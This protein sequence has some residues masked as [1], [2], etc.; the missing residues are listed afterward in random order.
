MKLELERKDPSK[1][2]ASKPESFTVKQALMTTNV[3]TLT[4]LKAKEIID[5]PSKEGDPYGLDKPEETIVLAG[6]KLEQTLVLGKAVEKKGAFS[7]EPD[8]YCRI[9]GEATV[10]LIDG[11]S[12]KGLKTDPAE[13]RDR[14]VLSFNPADIERLRDRA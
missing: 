5:E 1:W 3:R 6:P 2:V 10:Y 13:L 12:L 9:Q 4:N 14:S 8:R 7:K 11:R